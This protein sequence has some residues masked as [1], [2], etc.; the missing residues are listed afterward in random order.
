MRQQR[1]HGNLLLP[2]LGMQGFQQRGGPHSQLNEGVGGDPVSVETLTGSTGFTGRKQAE[3]KR[4]EARGKA[5]ENSR[6]PRALLMFW[7]AAVLCRL[8]PSRQSCNPV[9]IRPEQQDL[10][11]TN[12]QPGLPAPPCFSVRFDSTI[13]TFR[14]SSIN[15]AG[16]LQ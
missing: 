1:R 6:T 11:D 8:S 14:R 12:A 7:T 2:Q 3:R 5:G 15:V 16:A 9:N 13:A 4:L 10:Q